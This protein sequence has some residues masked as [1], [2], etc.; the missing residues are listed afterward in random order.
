[1]LAVVLVAAGSAAWLEGSRVENAT[2]TVVGGNRPVN[3]GATDPVDLTAHNSPTLRA[4]PANPA[5]LALVNRIDSLTSSCALHV[6]VDGGATWLA[7]PLPL[8]PGRAVA[9]FSPDLAFGADGTLY[10]AYTSFG[11][12]EGSGTVP[13]AVWLVTSHDRGTTLSAPA[14]VAGPLAFQLR[15]AADP[16]RP[17]RLY[18]AWLQGSQ[19]SSW[20]FAGDGDPIVVARSDDGGAT[21]GKPVAVSPASRRRAVAPSLAVTGAGALAVAYLDVGNDRLDYNGGHEGRGGDPYPGHWSLLVARSSD[22]GTTWRE[23]VVDA[24]IVPTQR[25][26]MFFPPAPAI[27]VDRGSRRLYVAFHDGRLGDADV[28]VWAS[29]VGG[30]PWGTARRVNDTPRGDGRA[31]YL[32]QLAVTPDGRVDVVYYDRRG[33]AADVMN[34]VS[35]QS[36]FDGARS[37]LRRLQVSDRSFDSRIGFGSDRELPDLGDRLGIVATDA[38]ALTV[39]TDTRSGLRET[40]KQDLAG[41]VIDVSPP[42]RGPAALRVAGPALVLAGM[43]LA[44]FALKRRHARAVRRQPDHSQ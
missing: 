29:G 5:D 17:G 11:E 30:E 15:F 42:R 13:D 1:M 8:P 24:G 40:G 34:T 25:F 6:S 4:N 27:A 35:V 26:L 2:I 36:S 39:W 38:G 28:W 22:G 7:R 3:A 18:L 16:A 10:V 12:V 20:G 19:T 23:A 14:L 31:Q 33:D 43:V 9:C 44:V 21:W 41:A 32:P 37:F